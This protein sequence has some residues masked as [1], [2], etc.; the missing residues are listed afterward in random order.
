MDK[1]E[2][3]P[4][5]AIREVSFLMESKHPNVIKLFDVKYSNNDVVMVMELLEMDLHHYIQRQPYDRS[6]VNSLD[7]TKLIIYQIMNGV[8]YLNSQKL[9]V[10]HRDIKPQNI[11]ISPK[12]N[13]LVK[14]A[15]MGLGRPMAIPVGTQCYSSEVVTLW[16]RAPELLLGQHSRSLELDVWSV[17]CVVAEMY[18]KKP[19]FRGENNQDQLMVIARK[20]GIFTDEVWPGVSKFTEYTSNLS[21][22]PRRD[23]V[24]SIPEITDDHGKVLLR[25]LLRPPPRGDAA[26]Y[27]SYKWFDNSICPFHNHA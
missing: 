7:D 10:T 23:I 17:G 5:T 1:N 15:D 22:F 12:K 2:G 13:L 9:K 14:L 11:L 19:L 6:I 26:A 8:A 4:S 20:M 21:N 27:L 25:S 3:V 24:D 16:Y 18:A